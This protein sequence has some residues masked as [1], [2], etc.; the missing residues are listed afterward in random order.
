MTIDGINPLEGVRQPRDSK[1][2]SDVKST[3]KAEDSVKSGA[4][5]VD[6]A[7]GDVAAFA[8]QLND[9]PD[10]R[11]DRIEALQREISEG[12][13]KVPSDDLARIILGELV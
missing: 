10:V 1:V 3:D 12:T 4:D 8:A 13:Y 9:I 2:E 6:V 5:K 7:G 11:S